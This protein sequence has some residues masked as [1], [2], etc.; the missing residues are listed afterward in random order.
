[1]LMRYLANPLYGIALFSALCMAAASQGRL[2]IVSGEGQADIQAGN[3][4]QARELAL[5]YA[6]W[7]AVSK[8]LGIAIKA[9]TL[10]EN[11]SVVEDVILSEV[12]GVVRISKIV[13]EQ[14]RGNV[15]YVRIDAIVDEGGAE[16]KVEQMIRNTSLVVMLPAAMAGRSMPQNAVSESII[17]RLT[18]NQYTV[19]DETAL[20]KNLSARDLEN[21]M[22]SSTV[23]M[24]SAA[25]KFLSNVAIVGKIEGRPT[26]RPGDVV[27]FA[28]TAN[29]FAVRATATYRVVSLSGGGLAAGQIIGSGTSEAMG[30]G[31]NEAV[32]FDNAVRSLAS[33]AS[34][35]IVS[36]YERYFDSARR[37]VEIKVSGAIDLPTHSQ[38]KQ[39]IGQ[40]KW[41]SNLR[42]LGLGHFSVDYA[43]KPIY[44]AHS[45]EQRQTFKVVSYNDRLIEVL[46]R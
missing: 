2:E 22:N 6:R 24:R 30:M 18:E 19:I 37:A 9:S 31:N 17:Q 11:A 1:M 38:I 25:M 23:A 7:D 45:L 43:E 46:K 40:I 14:R 21:L 36:R 5:S 33:T 10:V 26:I 34:S 8:K 15:M 32:A 27:P 29:Y 3:V 44:L 41:A 16:K 13:E 42:D 28:G 4:D 39:L 12:N 20:A 35:E